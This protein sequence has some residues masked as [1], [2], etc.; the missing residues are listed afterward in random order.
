MCVRCL[1]HLSIES[2]DFIYHTHLVL[3]QKRMLHTYQRYTYKV[4]L[5][6]I[7]IDTISQKGI[8]LGTILAKKYML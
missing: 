7:N 2:N 3:K 6:K 5:E 1:L 4:K 8:N